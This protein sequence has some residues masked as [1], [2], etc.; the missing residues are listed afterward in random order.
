MKYKSVIVTKRGGPEV[1]QVVENDLRLP[2]AGEVRIK[3]LT[4]PVCLPDVEARYGRSPFK[5]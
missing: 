5:P 4:T 1:L 3:I 2:S